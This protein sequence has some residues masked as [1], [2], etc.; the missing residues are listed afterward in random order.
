MMRVGAVLLQ[1]R[2]IRR[3]RWR[4]LREEIR[5]LVK[6]EHTGEFVVI[7]IEPGAYGIDKDE[8]AALDLLSARIP[9]V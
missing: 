2:R 3:A 5:L 4:D 6:P 1:H 9:N 8:I 7:D